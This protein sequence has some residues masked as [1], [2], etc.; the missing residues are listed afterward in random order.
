MPKP[1]IRF[2]GQDSYWWAMVDDAKVSC[3]ASAWVAN[4]PEPMTHS[5]MMEANSVTM[6]KHATAFI[7][8]SKFKMFSFCFC[9]CVRVQALFFFRL[10]VDTC[11]VRQRQFQREVE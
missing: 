4:N 2:T 11:H 5:E 10:S 3:A 6:V 7:I 9:A 1:G 8:C